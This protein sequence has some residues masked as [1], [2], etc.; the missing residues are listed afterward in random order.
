MTVD[1]ITTNKILAKRD[2]EEKSAFYKL[3]GI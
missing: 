3:M 1:I 2:A